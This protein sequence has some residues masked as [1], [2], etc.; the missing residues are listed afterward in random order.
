MIGILPKLA[1]GVYF[2]F[3]KFLNSFEANRAE[4][5]VKPLHCGKALQEVAKVLV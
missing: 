5:V 4:L 3:G 1:L 2:Y